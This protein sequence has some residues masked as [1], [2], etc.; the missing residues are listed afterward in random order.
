MAVQ[1]EFERVRE[2]TGEDVLIAPADANP[3]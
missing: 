3:A 1:A 2:R